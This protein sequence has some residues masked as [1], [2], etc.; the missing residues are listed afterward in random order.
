MVPIIRSKLR[1]GIGLR[2][3]ALANLW[4]TGLKHNIE[5]LDKSK[6]ARLVWLDRARGIALLLMVVYHF[7]WDL[8]YYHIISVDI[9]AVPQWQW[10]ARFVA[11]S[12]IFLSGVSLQIF[13]LNS[14]SWRRFLRREVKLLIAALLVSLASFYLMGDGFV[15]FGILHAIFFFSFIALLFLSAPALISL[16][17]I[18]LVLLLWWYLPPLEYGGRWLF[19]TGL[20]SHAPRSVDFVPVF[21]WFA[22]M[23]AGIVCAKVLNARRMLFATNTVKPKSGPLSWAGRQSLLIYLVHQPVLIVA[24]NLSLIVFPVQRLQEQAFVNSC[25]NNCVVGQ[26]KTLCQQV[27]SCSLRE[28]QKHDAWNMVLSNDNSDRLRSTLQQAYESCRGF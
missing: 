15:R 7:T 17:G 26:E 20:T 22:V 19:W 1:Y 18:S 25:V 21:P 23:L 12:F 16:I 28:L 27:C 9:M 24:I 10:F 4:D 5:I 8:S 6:G 13:A 3:Y 2:K 11:G 14:W